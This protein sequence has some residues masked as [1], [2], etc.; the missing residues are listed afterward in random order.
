M[1]PTVVDEKL[2]L[3]PTTAQSYESAPDGY[4][5][6]LSDE[7]ETALRKEKET[8]KDD[9]DGSESLYH[10]LSRLVL[11]KPSLETV[12]GSEGVLGTIKGG[13][14]RL[15]KWLKE[16]LGW[17]RNMIF[18]RKARVN[19]QVEDLAQLI[20]TGTLKPK[21]VYPHSIVPLCPIQ[22]GKLGEVPGN[23][24]WL[25]AEQKRVHDFVNTAKVIVKTAAK[26]LK[27]WEPLFRKVAD[28][29]EVDLAAFT[30]PAVLGVAL[31]GPLKLPI[32]QQDP[33]DEILHYEGAIF[34]SYEANIS[35]VGNAMVFSV[36]KYN[37]Y[38]G[39]QEFSTSPS[40]AKDIFTENESLGS[41]LDSLSSECE[42]TLKSAIKVLERAINSIPMQSRVG[43][44][45]E[46]TRFINSYISVVSRFMSY[47]TIDVLKIQEYINRTL[48]S[49]YK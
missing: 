44:I 28:G 49:A 33:Y 22:R 38:T 11:P 45:K 7:T 1:Y 40:T 13:L 25:K 8:R 31:W 34:G 14:S 10:S 2:V 17:L 42:D 48:L 41:A 9:V 32:K 35:V 29:K 36:S 43:Q 37:G 23:L 46:A 27:E 18:G 20:K 30:K 21:A 47:S 15:W 6:M 5:A 39:K 26:Q 4:D 19:R 24:E 16:F 12:E 3:S